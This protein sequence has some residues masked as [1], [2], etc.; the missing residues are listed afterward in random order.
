[1]RYLRAILP[2]RCRCCLSFQSVWPPLCF[3]CYA[4]LPW[5]SYT[6]VRCATKQEQQFVRHC[7]WCPTKSTIIQQTYAA[8]HYQP[9]ISR[10]LL[11]LKFQQ[12]LHQAVVLGHL[13]ADYLLKHLNHKPDV[14]IPV[15]LHRQRLRQRGFNQAA[16]ISHVLSQRLKIP[17]DRCL[18][19][20]VKRTSPQPGLGPTARQQNLRQ[21]FH[22]RSNTTYHSVAIVDDIIT[23]G[24]TVTAL[25][26]VLQQTAA[27]ISVFA[28]AKVSLV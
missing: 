14:L 19:A 17:I 1:M 15:P 24:A 12:Q 13:L 25:A 3:G 8:F 2:Q 22:C 20:R 16:L 21:A 27:N 26:R 10:W 9:P 7:A 18:A 5:Q 6:C 4:D 28:V 11:Q 23:T